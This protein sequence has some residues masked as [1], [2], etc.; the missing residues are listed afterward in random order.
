M[1]SKILSKETCASCKFCCSFRRQSL[2]ETPIFSEKEMLFLSEKFPEVKF[3]SRGNSFTY[4]LSGEY[5]T[6]N[7]EEEAKC[8]FL[9]EK[10]GCI[11]SKTEK[12]FDCSIWPL[13][14]VKKNEEIKIVLDNVCPA[15]KNIPIEEIRDLVFNG[16]AQNIISKASENPDMLKSDSEQFIEL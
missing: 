10:T 5:K 11:L 15:F 7:P 2:W 8:P 9:N 12:P 4:D 16:L 3:I 1:V 14:V 13:R 6:N